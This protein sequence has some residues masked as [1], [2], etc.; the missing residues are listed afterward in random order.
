MCYHFGK[1]KKAVVF[2]EL[3]MI[4]LLNVRKG[5]KTWT[6]GKELSYTVNKRNLLLSLTRPTVGRPLVS[7]KGLSLNSCESELYTKSNACVVF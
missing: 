5:C 6:L 3:L 1:S 4:G 2:A 7:Q